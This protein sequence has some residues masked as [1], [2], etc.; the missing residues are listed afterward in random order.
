MNSVAFL[1]KRGKMQETKKEFRKKSYRL[2]F[3]PIAWARCGWNKCSGFYDT[4]ARDKA[5]MRIYLENQHNDEPPFNRP[6]QLDVIFYMP[7][8]A[9]NLKWRKGIFK[10]HYHTYAPDL[11]NLIKYLLDSIGRGLILSDDKIIASIKA[12]K[13]YVP[14]DETRTEFSITEVE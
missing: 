3:K 4:Q 12:C 10:Q 6:S 14:A 9:G 13:V 8:P 7:I 5:V 2:D 1:S 11:D